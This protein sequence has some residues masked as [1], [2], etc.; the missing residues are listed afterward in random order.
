MRSAELDRELD[1]AFA[2]SASNEGEKTEVTEQEDDRPLLDDHEIE[3]AHALND[4]L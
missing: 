1:A 4:L 2:N 3:I